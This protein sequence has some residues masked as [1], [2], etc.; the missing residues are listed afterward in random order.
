MVKTPLCQLVVNK[1]HFSVS[2]QSPLS[3]GRHCTASKGYRINC[4]VPF[5]P[6]P[7][8]FAFHATIIAHKMRRCDWSSFCKDHCTSRSLFDFI[9]SSVLLGEPT[10]VMLQK[11]GLQVQPCCILQEA[12]RLILLRSQRRESGEWGAFQVMHERVHI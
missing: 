9:P 3:L 1:W 5:D 2:R 12:I 11:A 10:P 7:M 8:D 6:I 4:W